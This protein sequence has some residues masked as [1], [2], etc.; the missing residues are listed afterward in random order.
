MRKLYFILALLLL[1]L[2]VASGAL[3]GFYNTVIGEEL[4]LTKE[5]VI[6]EE[7]EEV[8]EEAEYE[9]VT[10]CLGDYLLEAVNLTDDFSNIDLEKISTGTN[11][12]SALLLG[13]VLVNLFKKKNKEK[14]IEDSAKKETFTRVSVPKKDSGEKA[15]KPRLKF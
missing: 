15:D 10:Y 9:L 3:G 5:A 14:L 12:G 7:T 6:D 4:V 11:A 1:A 8:L 2:F 13:I